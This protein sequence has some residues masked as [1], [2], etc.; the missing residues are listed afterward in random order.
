M[1]YSAEAG[2]HI[3]NAHMSKA[4]SW[5]R[6]VTLGGLIIGAIGGT[7]ASLGH[8]T[9]IC[10]AGGAAIGYTVGKKGENMQKKRLDECKF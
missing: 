5:K 6:K 8:G 2:D 10:G 7:F 1:K 9:A 3:K 4:R